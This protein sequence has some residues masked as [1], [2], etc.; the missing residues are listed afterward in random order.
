M[1]RWADFYVAEV[2][3][4]AALAGLLFVA[5]S[6][7]IEKI[8]AFPHLPARAAQTLIIIGGSLTL[9]G[10]GLFPTITQHQFGVVAIVIAVTLLIVGTRSYLRNRSASGPN[11]KRLWALSQL[12]TDVVAALPMAAGGLLLTHGS[13]IGLSVIGVAIILCFVATMHSGWVLL[14]EILR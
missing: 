2:G 3:A 12:T 14:V 1:E 5:I 6:F 11:A 7:N 13:E 4:A 9:A 10:F 8:L